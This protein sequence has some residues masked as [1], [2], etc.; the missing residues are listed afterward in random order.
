MNKKPIRIGFDLDGVIAKH[1]LG[2]LWVQLR[3]LKEKI[4]KK[5]HSSCYYYPSMLIE[6]R[7]WMLIDSRKR[8][9]ADEKNIFNSL[10]E[11][12]KLRFY[13]V[14]GRF[15]FLERLTRKWLIKHDLI[16]NFRQLLINIEDIDPIVFKAQT[17][18]DLKLN[19][20]ID[21]DLET[22]NT[23]KKKTK[24]EFLWIVPP[25]KDKSENGDDRVKS[26]THVL[27]ALEEII[28][29]SVSKN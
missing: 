11:K 22:I 16:N 9:F 26:C 28:D 8:P 5:K 20:F 2:G 21:D 27:E 25:H 13:L 4:L 23:L 12:R 17:I 6:K 18:N 1:S 15:K 3:K 19:F 14:T 7:I 29:L 24:A 10:A